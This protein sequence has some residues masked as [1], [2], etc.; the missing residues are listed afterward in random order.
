[1]RKH[2]LL[3]LSGTCCASL[4]LRWPAGSVIERV[5]ARIRAIINSP[6]GRSQTLA[7][8]SCII[9]RRYYLLVLLAE[10]VAVQDHLLALRRLLSLDLVRLC[11]LRDH[12]LVVADGLL[13]LHGPCFFAL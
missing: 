8:D 2:L 6:S 4:R 1:M 9:G 12:L 7:L 13:Q 11:R 10:V 5:D 3:L